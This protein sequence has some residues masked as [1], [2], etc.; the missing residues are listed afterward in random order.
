M[1]MSTLSLSSDI[2]EEGIRSHYRWLF[3]GIEL[4]TFGR[5][6]SA[7]NCCTI[8]P[9]PLPLRLSF[10][11]CFVLAFLLKMIGYK[12][13]CL[14]LSSL[15]FFT[16][17]CVS[18]TELCCFDYYSFVVYFDISFYYIYLYVCMCTHMLMHMQL[19]YSH[20]MP[21]TGSNPS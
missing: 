17:L 12:C 14:F 5:V 21:R 11:Y 4:R 2:P 9:A 6:G 15:F 20:V 13:V 3:L 18:M 19:G 10:S 8:S 1:Y 16:D 7:F